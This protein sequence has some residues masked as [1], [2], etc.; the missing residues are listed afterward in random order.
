MQG[1]RSPFFLVHAGMP[2][3]L[4]S[5]SGRDAD[6]PFFLVQVIVQKSLLYLLADG[7]SNITP[8]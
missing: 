7:F 6:R 4:F 1:C 2:I 8:I 3:A 5:Y